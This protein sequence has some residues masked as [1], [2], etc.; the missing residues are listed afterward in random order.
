[1][2]QK[3][4]KALFGIS[5]MVKIVTYKAGT[6]EILRETEWQPNLI[7]LGT[8][9]GKSLI[10]QRLASNN[11]YSLNVNY[12]GL[13]TSS[14]APAVSDTQLGSEQVRQPV[15]SQSIASNV[16]TL[17]FFFSDALTPNNTYTEFGTFVDASATANSGQIF[18]HILFGTSYVK[19]SGEDTT[20][21]LTLTIT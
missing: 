2:N 8:N 19:V 11:T 4:V 15:S 14:T 13:G 17:Q 10:L 20:V 7:M 3:N 9:T 16:L 12:A 5:G 18:N 1:M 6:K 21:Q